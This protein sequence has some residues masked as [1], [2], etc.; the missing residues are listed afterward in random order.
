[1]TTVVVGPR[2]LM[3]DESGGELAF[4]SIASNTVGVRSL[5]ATGT[6]SVSLHPQLP[7]TLAGRPVRVRAVT[8]CIDADSPT[9]DVDQAFISTFR[10]PAPATEVA[11][12]ED[13]TNRNDNVCRRYALPAAFV[14]ARRTTLT[15]GVRMSWT[16]VDGR[17]DFAGDDV[18]YERT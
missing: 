12:F 10:G 2:A 16:A 7:A 5:T 17:L 14:L 8:L 18:E 9:A 11:H 6:D 4:T 1:M 3:I 13:G 15:V